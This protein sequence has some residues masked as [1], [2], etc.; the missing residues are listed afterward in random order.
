VRDRSCGFPVASHLPVLLAGGDA[1]TVAFE[2]FLG[3]PSNDGNEFMNNFAL[4]IA[5]VSPSQ[6]ERSCGENSREKFQVLSRMGT[7]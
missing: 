5:N 4:G 7:R 3:N 1:V 6:L 2:N